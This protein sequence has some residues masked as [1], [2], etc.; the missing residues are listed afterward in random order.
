MAKDGF[1]T[2]PNARFL[3][4]DHYAPQG[5]SDRLSSALGVSALA[6]AVA[7][8]LTVFAITRL[9]LSDHVD[10][11]KVPLA[12]WL[13]KAGDPGGGGSGSKDSKPPRSLESRGRDAAA[14]PIAYASEEAAKD[15]STPQQTVDMPAVSTMSGEREL[16]GVMTELTRVTVADS[17]GPG[18]GGRSGDGRQ[19]GNGSGDGPGLRSGE[20]GGPGGEGYTVGNGVLAPRLIREIKP[21]YTSEALR[22]RI[23]GTVVL[24]T[25]ILPDGS[26]GSTRIIRSLDGRFGL[27]EEASKTVKLWRFVPGTLAGRPVPVIV[28]IEL[29]FTLR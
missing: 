20:R 25:T 1:E 12:V 18:T 16:P 22:A 9:P 23:Q 8:V 24:R 17:Q 3:A 4:W 13:P 6:H 26:V 19:L 10:L 11:L 27:D 21:G 7:F 2:G 5:Q 15:R 14:V 28:D 29:T